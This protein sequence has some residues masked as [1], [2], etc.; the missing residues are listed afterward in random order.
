MCRKKL[1]AKRLCSCIKNFDIQYAKISEDYVTADVERHLRKIGEECNLLIEK[2]KIKK[3]HFL[4]SELDEFKRNFKIKIQEIETKNQKFLQAEINRFS[5]TFAESS[6]EYI[7]YQKECILQKL[8]QEVLERTRVVQLNPSWSVSAQWKELENK[9]SYFHKWIE[10]VNEDFLRRESLLHQDF[11]SNVDGKSLDAQQKV[12]VICDEDRVLVL[13]G[14]GSGKTL[15]ISAKVKYLCEYKNILPEDILLISF[16]RKS[17]EEMTQRIHDKLGISVE[18]KTFHKLGLDIIKSSHG[19]CPKVFDDLSGFIQDLFEKELLNY[20]DFIGML[21]DFFAYYL[22]LPK[23][24]SEYSSLGELYEAE[25]VL[26]LETLKSKYEKSKYINEQSNQRKAEIKTLKGERVKS[27]QETNIANFLFLNGIEYEYEKEYPFK[28]GDPMRK[29]YQPDFYLSEYDIYLEHF[30]INQFN[31]T[32]QLSKVEEEKYLE[33]IEW[34]R[35]VHKQYATKLIET[36]SYYFSEGVWREQLSNALKNMGVAFKTPDFID[37]YKTIYAKKNEKY[38]SEF[39]KLCCTFVNLFKSGGYELNDLDKM[40]QASHLLGKKDES[41]RDTLFLSIIKM[42]IEQYQNYLTDK[43]QIDL[44][45][46]INQASKELETGFEFHRYKYIIVDEYQDIS[47]ARFRLLKAIATFGNSKIFCVGDDWQSIYRFAGSDISLFINFEKYFGYTKVLRIEKT[48]RNSQE[49]IDC[50]SEFIV[51]NPLQLK[52]SLRSDTHLDYPLVFW[53]CDGQSS[54]ALEKIV[55]K[56]IQDFGPAKSILFLG[57]T[58]FDDYWLKNDF[59]FQVGNR[60][61]VVYLKSPA[62]PMQFLSVHKSK[63]LEADNVVLLNFKNDK[64]GFPNQIADD[65]VMKYVLNDSE[66]FPYAEERRLFYVAI[67]RTKNRAF[68]L[69]DSKNSSPFLKDFKRFENSK[70]VHFHSLKIQ[71]DSNVVNCPKCKTGI[72]HKVSANGNIFIG[73]SNF[74]RCDYTTKETSVLV[75]PIKCSNCGGFLIKRKAKERNFWFLGC[76]NYPRCPFTSNLN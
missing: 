46:M 36:Y 31:R 15:T 52:K 32:P 64:L 9:K 13:A 66:N 14:A 41:E 62:T 16:T 56:I 73:C 29:S 55:D 10:T 21:M 43:Q 28:E 34:K 60:G 75:N 4:F 17:A 40:M 68:I 44:S 3:S 72:L 8:C 22:D 20:P 59:N 27:L 48:Y 54:N 30:G 39:I 38:F 45:D 58:N 74:P 19:C 18:A 71:S 12:A 67:T 24:A 37:I 42:I 1:M 65:Q 69:T 61:R 50:A 5:E 76:T 35:N 49:L 33:G 53:G 23:D 6:K 47:K 70:N 25:K 63:G 11:F 26:D 51:Q 57:R 7:S 2:I